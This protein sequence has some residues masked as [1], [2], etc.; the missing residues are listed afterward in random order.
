MNERIDHTNYEAWLL[1]R[2]E[3]N[4]SPEQEGE[5]DAFLLKH[6][7]LAPAE[8]QLPSVNAIAQALS[9]TE[10][11]VLKKS[12]P[13]VRVV[14]GASMEHHLVARLENDLTADQREALR[15]YLADHPE[16][17]RTERIYALTKLVPEAIAYTE[18]RRLLRF[19]PPQGMP[20]P[21]NLDD[22]LVARL[23]GDLTRE[24]EKAVERFIAQDKAHEHAWDLM[25]STRYPTEAIIFV[26]KQGLKK[27]GG[28]VI[29]FT[30]GT[31]SVRLAAAAS[32]A[33]LIGLGLWFLRTPDGHDQE[34][35]RVPSKTE[36]PD[37]RGAQNEE[38]EGNAPETQVL[39]DGHSKE[40]ATSR[41]MKDALMP[42]APR[43][44]QP[45]LPG[46]VDPAEEPVLAQDV[47]EPALNND[48][49]AVPV[50]PSASEQHKSLA[51]GTPARTDAAASGQNTTTLGELL[52]STVRDRVLDKPE[53]EEQTLDGEDA[54]AMVD[55]T[56]KVVGG[57]RAGLDVG[58]KAQ[59]GTRRFDLRL[60]RNF[61]ISAS[62]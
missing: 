54:I 20:T 3:G 25:R 58:Q 31:W 8:G 59:N 22:F 5:L 55:R 11:E 47:P 10:K 40:D 35:A 26:D 42:A 53:R 29:P 23:E 48:P 24:Q 61:S 43:R 41:Q 49:A 34:I 6:P 46:R 44:Q 17:H 19:F 52:A 38:Q 45:V 33:L 27:K 14:D 2:L 32:V 16:H 60:G 50:M 37:Q 56:L 13:P 4:L 62:R 57:E 1:D 9:T 51:A 30:L 39:Q 15:S 7:E 28:R 12:I 18:K 36:V 21:F